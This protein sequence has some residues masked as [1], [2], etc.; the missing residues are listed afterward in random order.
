MS[1]TTLNSFQAR[2]AE[3][4][5]LKQV[6]TTETVVT[7]NH[8]ITSSVKGAINLV[9]TT[10]GVT[11]DLSNEVINTT[12]E[13]VELLPKAIRSIKAYIR[14]SYMTAR[15]EL[16][17]FSPDQ[18]E[19]LDEVFSSLP[20]AQQNKIMQKDAVKN[21]QRLGEYLKQL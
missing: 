3:L 20:E 13:A 12:A 11:V 19:L 15:S 6:A 16:S 7:S 17:G 4:K 18:L 9:K 2:M 21:L 1:N 14:A 5:A 10:V 8:S